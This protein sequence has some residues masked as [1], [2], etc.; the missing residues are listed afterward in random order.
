MPINVVKCLATLDA[1]ALSD[2]R[3]QC[4]IFFHWGV[5][6]GGWIGWLTRKQNIKKMK[7]VLNIMMEIRQ[8][9]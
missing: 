7:N 4:Y 6:M 3:I 2:W 5:F 1:F 8:T 9:L